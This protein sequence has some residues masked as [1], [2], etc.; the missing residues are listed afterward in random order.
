MY[1]RST[2]AVII[3]SF[4]TALPLA[5]HAEGELH[6]AWS[7]VWV[8]N[9]LVVK[10]DR[11]YTSGAKVAYLNSERPV[12]SDA[13]EAA[14]GRW[15]PDFGLQT[16]AIRW[17]IALSQDI[18]TPADIQ[19]LI[20]PPDDRPY[21]GYLYTTLYLQKRGRTG[22][23]TEEL[24]Q[25]SLDL[26]IVGPP[27]LGE[28]AQNTVH[29]LRGFDTAKGWGS[30]LHT[31]PAVNLH[32]LRTLRYTTS[33]GQG[34]QADFLPQYGVTGGTTYDFAE[35]GG[36]V[37][38]GWNLADDFGRRCNQ[39]TLPGAG[40][41][42]DTDGHGFSIYGLLGLDGRAVAHNT[43]LEGNLFQ[44]SRSVK[45]RHFVGE[46]KAGVGLGWGRWEL[47]YIQSLRSKEYVRQP[48][49]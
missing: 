14:V 29:R 16:T 5:I 20:P 32:Y 30:Q 24:D 22:R 31:E 9:D 3:A 39:E 48:S 42:S 23:G 28:L 8:E 37:R 1:S 17:G 13:A 18:Y 33:I 12:D 36:Q 40:G 43:L 45:I 15:L 46:V 44:E 38:L 34:L 2:G 41:R 7:T 26:G 25:W 19:A 11:H 21:A 6:S 4:L 47:A 35:V 10:T 27:A 49:V